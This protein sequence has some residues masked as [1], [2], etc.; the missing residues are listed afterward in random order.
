MLTTLSWR[1][2]RC[3]IANCESHLQEGL[4]ECKTTALDNSML[5]ASV[6]LATMGMNEK[7]VDCQALW[8][9]LG[10]GRLYFYSFDIDPRKRKEL[11]L[12][13]TNALRNFLQL[14]RQVFL[15]RE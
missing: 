13:N 8:V 6:S 12:N 5:T 10:H 7:K 14:N 11:N 1:I 15:V 9:Y 4:L 2:D 3:D